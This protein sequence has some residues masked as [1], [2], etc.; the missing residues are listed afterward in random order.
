[1]SE[2]VRQRLTPLIEIHTIPN[3]YQPDKGISQGGWKI[4]FINAREFYLQN[5]NY[6]YEYK[7][8]TKIV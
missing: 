4:L 6:I 5:R 2:W 3:T 1:M 8:F 7:F